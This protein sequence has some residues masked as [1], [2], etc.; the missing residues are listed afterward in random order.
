MSAHVLG[1]LGG[2]LLG[3]LPFAYLIV[4]IS[5]SVDIRASG[6]GNAGGFNAFYVTKSKLIGVVVGVVDGLKGVAAAGVPLLMG[7]DRWVMALALLGAIV[8]HNYPVWMRFKGGRGL[9]TACG[10]LMIIGIAY[11][12]IWCSIWTLS[13]VQVKDILRSNILASVLTPLLLFVMP[14]AFVSVSFFQSMT[15]E[16]YRILA[17]LL[18][19]LFLLSHWKPVV[20]VFRRRPDVNT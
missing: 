17:F 12:I 8:G 3:S 10:G 13:K 6:S 9:A 19:A 15:A 7:A 11:T 20:Q 1:F 4:R 14:D 2:Y 5:S 16:D 18:T